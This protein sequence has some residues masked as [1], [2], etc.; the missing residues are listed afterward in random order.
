MD[1]KT[2]L[3]GALITAGIA[4]VLASHHFNTA[5]TVSSTKSM[6]RT[7]EPIMPSCD[8][9]KA[10]LAKDIQFGC[11]TFR[12]PKFK[13]MCEKDGRGLLQRYFPN[14][15]T[16]V[17]AVH[18]QFSYKEMQS[19]INNYAKYAE[20]IDLQKRFHFALFCSSELSMKWEDLWGTY[21]E[22]KRQP[23]CQC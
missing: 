5:S 15:E 6:P 16:T 2:L 21:Y 8:A 20:D 4:G 14:S 7:G 22:S 13:D 19:K 3:V 9:F 17:E 18:N 11:T 1:N 10:I 23:T 12:H